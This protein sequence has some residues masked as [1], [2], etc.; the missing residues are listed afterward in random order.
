[1]IHHG[2]GPSLAL[3]YVR[4]VFL[5]IDY[6]GRHHAMR[7]QIRPVHDVHRKSASRN[8]TARNFH[9]AIRGM[10]WHSTKS[11]REQRQEAKGHANLWQHGG[12]EPVLGNAPASTVWTSGKSKPP[13]MRVETLS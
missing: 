1:M 7:A 9:A 13:Q 11:K 4:T 5:F 10:T 2:T 12:S 3:A 6:L 8:S